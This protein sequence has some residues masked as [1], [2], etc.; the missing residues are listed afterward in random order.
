[1]VGG[2]GVNMK[3][4]GWWWWGVGCVNIKLVG[5]GGCEGVGCVN[6]E[7]VGGGGGGGGWG[8]N[9]SDLIGVVVPPL[10]MCQFQ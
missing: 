1:M 6:N 4:R 10:P 7:L 9:I 3:V 2:W 5:G 8:V